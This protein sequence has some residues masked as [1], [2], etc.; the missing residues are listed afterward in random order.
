[1]CGACSKHFRE[2]RFGSMHCQCTMRRVTSEEDTY[3]HKSLSR[4]VCTMTH[5]K[6]AALQLKQ[7][8]FEAKFGWGGKREPC[9][10]QTTRQQKA[11]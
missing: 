1:M 9:I 7:I 5:M 2:L 6:T 10:M 3:T 4:H 8:F 11:D